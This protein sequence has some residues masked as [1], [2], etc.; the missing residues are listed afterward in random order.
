MTLIELKE[1]L[2][3]HR[4][5]QLT[6]EYAS[7][8]FTEPDF[9]ITEIK[10]CA[11]E[12]V[13]CGGGLEYWNESILQLWENPFATEIQRPMTAEKALSIIRKVEK[14]HPL[15]DDS[16]V[17]FEYGNHRFHTCVQSVSATTSNARMLILS[18]G[19]VKADC[20]DKEAC[21]I[22]V[23]VSKLKSSKNCTPGSGCC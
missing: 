8:A 2:E 16:L 4:E 5:K 11:I 20:K 19:E 18:L 3:L 6:F 23:P 13:N 12:A 1:L 22:A 21:G 15:H 9:H 14:A 10:K 7:G 17:R